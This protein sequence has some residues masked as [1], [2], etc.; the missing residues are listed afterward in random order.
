MQPADESSS[1][2]PQRSWFQRWIKRAWW[3]HSCVGLS[4][5]VG[6]MIYA[7][8]GLEYADKVLALL[9]ISWCVMFVA[10]R[11][12]VGPAN[13]RPDEKLHR[14]GIRLATNY[15]IKNMYQQMFYFLVPLYANSATWSFHS[16]NWWLAPVLLVCAVLSTL[17]LV[18]DN[19]IME[20]RW[21]ASILYGF[22]LF[23]VLNLMLPLAFGMHHFLALVI[24]ASATAPAV[25]LLNF[26]PRS[27]FGPEG[28][29]WTCAASAALFC[30]AWFGRDLVPPAPMQMV[31][32]AVGHGTMGSQECVPA[33][34]AYIPAD[35]LDGLRCGSV[36]S[37]PGG[38]K[39]PI[40]HVWRH[41]GEEVF[42]AEIDTDPARGGMLHLDPCGGEIVDRSILPA[43]RIP[44]DPLG[45]WDCRVETADGQLVGLM[46][47]EIVPPAATPA[48]ATPSDPQGPE[49]GQV[50]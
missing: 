34:K 43:A 21:I 27:V 19:F 2:A 12:I 42:R 24:A 13:R 26:S 45:D 16:F 23:G 11:F 14:K 47:F 50:H 3:L 7:K 44:A 38:V 9:A 17:D 46:R 20:R 48:P 29:L 36:V 22:A 31:A 32:G 39:D 15:V 10:L 6:V 37:E 18:F 30:G 41:K 35:Q 33:R 8:K 40:V 4:F 5:G 49:K 28:L 25:A 1:P